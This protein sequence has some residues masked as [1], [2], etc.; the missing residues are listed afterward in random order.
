M[1]GGGWW[2]LKN[3]KDKFLII[4]AQNVK[5]KPQGENMQVAWKQ[6]KKKSQLLQRV[7]RGKQFHRQQEFNGILPALRQPYSY[8]EDFCED[9]KDLSYQCFYRFWSVHTTPFSSFLG[10]KIFGKA[11]FGKLDWVHNSHSCSSWIYLE[12]SEVL[13]AMWINLL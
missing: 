5:D 4:I 11:L 2:I 8:L 10:I 3:R 7:L 1:Q 6:K 13:L 9:R 12:I